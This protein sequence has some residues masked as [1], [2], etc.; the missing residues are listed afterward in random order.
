[1]IWKVSKIL[2][3]NILMIHIVSTILM[4]MTHINYGNNWFIK[5]DLM[6][7]SWHYQYI[8]SYYWATIIVTTIGF[9][10]ISPQTT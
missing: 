4:A 8:T 2:G 10:D 9:G 3:L 5:Y 6:D 1:M 7:S